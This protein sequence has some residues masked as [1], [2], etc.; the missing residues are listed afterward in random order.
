MVKV[1]EERDDGGAIG[2]G[3]SSISP[4]VNIVLSFERLVSPSLVFHRYMP[5]QQS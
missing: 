2:H 4:H 1:V 5:P 3:D